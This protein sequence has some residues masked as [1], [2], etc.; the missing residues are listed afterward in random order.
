M[1]GFK[2]IFISQIYKR[3]IIVYIHH[4]KLRSAKV[5]NESTWLLLYIRHLIRNFAH[6]CY[7]KNHF[8]YMVIVITCSVIPLVPESGILSSFDNITN[9]FSVSHVTILGCSFFPLDHIKLKT[10]SGNQHQLSEKLKKKNFFVG[11]LPEP[12]SSHDILYLNIELLLSIS[13]DCW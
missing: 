4:G 9:H 6:L 8:D 5:Y 10:A 7:M 12:Y 3:R 13:G 11:H 1:H 2:N